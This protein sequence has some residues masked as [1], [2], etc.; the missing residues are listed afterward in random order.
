MRLKK[1]G[2]KLPD[3]NK[4][5]QRAI[6]LKTI[7]IVRGIYRTRLNSIYDL[8]PTYPLIDWGQLSN[9]Q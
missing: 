6:R 8:T 1:E 3:K 7:I 5:T 9:D 4:K 2:K